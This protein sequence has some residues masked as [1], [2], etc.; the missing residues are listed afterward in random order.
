MLLSRHFIT[1]HIATKTIKTNDIN[2]GILMALEAAIESLSVSGLA[3]SSIETGSLS[4]TNNA[5]VGENLTVMG[6]TQ[7]NA[8]SALTSIQGATVSGTTS[9][10]GSL[11]AATNNLTVQGR[12]THAIDVYS[13]TTRIQQHLRFYTRTLTTDSNARVTCYLTENGTA[14][15]TALFQTILAYGATATYA[16][17]NAYQNVFCTHESTGGDLKSI[18]FR[19]FRGV[20]LGTLS[21]TVVAADSGIT[22]NVW[23]LGITAGV[24]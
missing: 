11:V 20:A 13:N 3:A 19:A 15:G 12:E 10:T 22:V 17:S 7:A 16:G 23:V 8:V 4:V 24:S 18:L 2:T 5:T 1:D 21:P 6:S 14:G 9:V